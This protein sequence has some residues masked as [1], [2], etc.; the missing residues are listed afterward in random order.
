MT[1]S[2]SLKNKKGKNI[3][4]K[5]ILGRMED[6]AQLM[7]AME[8]TLMEWE[9]WYR[10]IKNQKDS[11]SNDEWKHIVLDGPIFTEFPEK[12]MKS[13]RENTPL[14]EKPAEEEEKKPILFDGSGNIT[15]ST[16]ENKKIIV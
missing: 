1:K 2:S 4:R 8:A 9:I 6:M 15:A 3:T 11:Y 14:L 16:D 7:V 5:M 10:L 13:V 12:I